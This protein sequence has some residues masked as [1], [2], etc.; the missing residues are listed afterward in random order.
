MPKFFKKKKI[1][2]RLGYI[3]EWDPHE[4]WVEERDASAGAVLMLWIRLMGWD[5][6]NR[7]KGEDLCAA[8]LTGMAYLNHV[9]I[10]RKCH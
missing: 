7:E 8:Y 6:K 5:L 10:H 9:L 1:S 2:Q 3:Y 4:M